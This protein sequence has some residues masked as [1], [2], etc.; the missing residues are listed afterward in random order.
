MYV[1]Q[2]QKKSTKKVKEKKDTPVLML[3][4]VSNVTCNLDPFLCYLKLTMEENSSYN[5]N[6]HFYT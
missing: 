6:K 4:S 2:C 5:H 3:L 1:V